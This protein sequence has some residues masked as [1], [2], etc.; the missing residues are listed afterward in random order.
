MKTFALGFAMTA[1]ALAG[2]ASA[3][4]VKSQHYAFHVSEADLLQVVAE[5]ASDAHRTL[6]LLERRGQSKDHPVLVSVPETAYLKC[7]IFIVS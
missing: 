1:A 7:L 3:D 2:W 4:T 5:A 6:R